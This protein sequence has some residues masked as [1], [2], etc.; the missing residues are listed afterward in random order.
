M[1]ATDSIE[2]EDGEYRNKDDR[3]HRHT[4][5]QEKMR[6]TWNLERRCFLDQ[7]ATKMCV[8]MKTFKYLNTFINALIETILGAY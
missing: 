5:E 8:L 2:D 6:I 3:E 4:A 1:L 7:S